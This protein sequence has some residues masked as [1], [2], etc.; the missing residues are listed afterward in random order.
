[1]SSRQL[2]FGG[3]LVGGLLG[4]VAGAQPWWKASGGGASVSFSGSEASGGLTWA[5]AAVVLAGT[6][7]AL[8]L[9]ARGRRVVASVVGLAGIGMV[10]TGALRQ[11]PATAGVRSRLAQ[12]SLVDTF[13][14]SATAWPWV[15]AIAGLLAAG[16]AAA[17]LVRAV[18]WP[19]RT[20]R[21]ERAATGPA[22][23][24]ADDPTQAWQALDAGQ[25]PTV[26]GSVRS[27]GDA[28][29]PR[30]PTSESADPDVQSSTP[31]DTMGGQG[32]SITRREP[33]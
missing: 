14:L 9:R 30:E 1:M 5:L 33:S 32:G 17:M 8:A 11:R 21:F 28:P 24:L 19:V 2:A 18:R 13:A 27:A 12:V 20:A 31:G 23:D 4:L 6:L 16:G 3:L 29:E 26:T 22:A 10:L 15:Y 25:D 7:L